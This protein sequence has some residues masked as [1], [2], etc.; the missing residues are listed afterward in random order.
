MPRSRCSRP[1]S[2]SRSMSS[3]WAKVNSGRCPGRHGLPSAASA[4]SSVPELAAAASA[5]TGVAV[6]F[7]GKSCAESIS[8]MDAC[9]AVTTS[10]MHPSIWQKT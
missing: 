2:M 4:G 8:L 10:G 6:M 3:C 1:V 7:A 5:A 9:I